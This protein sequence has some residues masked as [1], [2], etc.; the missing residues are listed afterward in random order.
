MGGRLID[1]LAVVKAKKK[2]AEPRSGGLFRLMYYK[3]TI[4]AP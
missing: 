3:I 1:T 2:P 4:Q